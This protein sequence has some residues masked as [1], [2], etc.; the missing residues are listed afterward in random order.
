MMRAQRGAALV[1]A[2]WLLTLGSVLA[3]SH[4]LATRTDTR[5][6]AATIAR[7]QARSAAE[8]GIWRAVYAVVNPDPLA[9]LPADG[10][11]VGFEFGGTMVNVRVQ[12]VHGLADLNRAN[13][14]ALIELLAHALDDEVRAKEIVEKLIDWRDKDQRSGASGA[15]A[16]DYRAAGYDWVPKDGPFTTREELTLLLGLTREEYRKIAP[17]VTVFSLNTSVNPR[18]APAH[19]LAAMTSLDQP[20]LA[21]DTQRALRNTRPRSGTFE[22]LAEATVNGS[23]GRLATTLNVNTRTRGR[24]PVTVLTWRES[25]PI[26]MPIGKEDELPAAF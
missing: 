8:A 3:F 20:Q 6:V 26:D 21:L 10:T 17:Y 16:A 18:V 5:I 14:F 13:P 19:V 1:L 22:I 23:V 11:A 12:D 2:L 25:W 24:S 4:T 7:H 9:P 15:E